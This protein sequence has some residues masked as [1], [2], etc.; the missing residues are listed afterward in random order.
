VGEPV[1]LRPSVGRYQATCPRCGLLLSARTGPA[2]RA[3]LES[4]ASI[5]HDERIEWR[6]GHKGIPIPLD[7]LRPSASAP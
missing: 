3:A 4:H 7:P 2:I 5:A 6:A 1:R